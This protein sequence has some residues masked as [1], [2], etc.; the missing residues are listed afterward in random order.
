[1]QS[2]NAITMASELFR[3]ARASKY[4]SDDNPNCIRAGTGT[5][6]CSTQVTLTSTFA[7]PGPGPG[8]APPHPPG[9]DPGIRPSGLEDPKAGCNVVASKDEGQHK[10]KTRVMPPGMLLHANSRTSVSGSTESN[11]R[12][13][14]GNGGSNS[15]SRVAAGGCVDVGVVRD[16]ASSSPT[17]PGLFEPYE[18]ELLRRMCE[19]EGEGGWASKSAK[20]PTARSGMTRHVQVPSLCLHP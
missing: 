6:S 17:Y 9:D 7:M 5:E 19:S 2:P 4:G 13:G 12:S 20:F 18:D 11:P 3:R 8:W 16:T 15:T 14:N 1:M 10:K